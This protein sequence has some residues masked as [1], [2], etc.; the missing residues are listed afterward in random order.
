MSEYGG[1]RFAQSESNERVNTINECGIDCKESWGYGKGET[2]ENAFVERYCKLT[3]L[4]LE[5]SKLSG[6]CYTQLYDIEQEQNGLFTYERVPKLSI[7][8]QEKIAECNL[9]VATIEKE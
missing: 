9:T 4:L 7:V 2:D 8:A 5:N 1:F 3:K 6:F